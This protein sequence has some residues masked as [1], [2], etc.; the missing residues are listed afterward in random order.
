MVNM[1]ASDNASPLLIACMRGHEDC[2]EVLLDNGAEPGI[3]VLVKHDETVQLYM[4]A[5]QYA[6]NY[7]HKRYYNIAS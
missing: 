7:N 5:L 6:T 4:D 2:V 1:T 3:Q